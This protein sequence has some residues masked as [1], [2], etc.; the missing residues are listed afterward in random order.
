[1]CVITVRPG[2]ISGVEERTSPEPQVDHVLEG[3]TAR[4]TLTGE[5]T[6]AARRP[7]VRVV[8]ELLLHEHALAA[9]VLDARGVS[10]MNSAGMAVLVQLLRMVAP[11]GVR[12]V[13]LD[14]SEAVRRPLQLSGL[15]RRFEVEDSAGEPGVAPTPRDGAS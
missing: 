11:R 5:L 1:L 4:L 13:L 6:D 15:W 9:V 12:M 14:P 7:L 2:N 3:D 10:F 8:T